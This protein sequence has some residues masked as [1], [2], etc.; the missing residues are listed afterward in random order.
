VGEAD[1]KRAAAAAA[2]ELEGD[3]NAKIG[4]TEDQRRQLELDKQQR[5]VDAVAAENAKNAGK[6]GE[7]RST[8]P[9]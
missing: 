6:P 8:H 2:K 4:S 7:P 5:V 1:D 9:G 3:P